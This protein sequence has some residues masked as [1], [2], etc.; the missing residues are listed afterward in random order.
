MAVW[1]ERY[2]GKKPVREVPRQGG[3][4][5]FI[6][7]TKQT[8]QPQPQTDSRNP[9]PISSTDVRGRYQTEPAASVETVR[10]VTVTADD[11]FLAYQ[12]Q[13]REKR[14]REARR[15]ERAELV[16]QAHVTEEA[17]RKEMLAE[18]EAWKDIAATMYAASM[19][20]KLNRAEILR[21]CEAH[22]LDVN[23]VNEIGS[24]L[25]AQGTHA[26]PL[27][28]EQAAAEYQRSKG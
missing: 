11:H 13:Q 14:E 2:Q 4:V 10:T 3:R 19:D 25:Q 12:T 5:R 17:R 6:D 27:C 15:A 24:K 26:I 7:Q 23:S 16:W 9:V 22:G 20:N 28:W 1:D 21:I 18:H 8:Q